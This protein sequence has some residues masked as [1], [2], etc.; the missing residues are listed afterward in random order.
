MIIVTGGAGFIGS[1][2]VWRLNEAGIKDILVVDQKA[3]G[4][5]KWSNLKKRRY[6][7]YLE[8]DALLSE[9]A[10]GKLSGKVEAVFHMGA[11]SSTTEMDTAYLRENNSLYSE[12]I[13]EF[14]LREGAYLC[15]ASSAATYGDGERG[16]DDRDELTPGLKPL[17][18]YG[19]SKLDFDRWVLDHGH[20]NRLTGLRFFNVYGP[21]EYHKDTMR[22]LVN[23][24]YEQV[25]DT[26]RL[27]LFK[28]YRPE[29]PDGGQRR[30][31]VY[32]KDVVEAM[33]WL[34]RNPGVKGIY[35]IGAGRAQSWNELAAALFTAMD[36]PLNVEYI[37]MPESI[38][39][40]YQYFTM[41]DMTKLRKAGCTTD[42][43]PVEGGVS[44]YVRN[45]LSKPDPYL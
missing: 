29:Y 35:N 15:Y 38:R 32:V 1:V 13:A 41:A 8:S 37:D 3:E 43:R 12:R 6:T 36:R 42:F 4:S 22:S 39:G 33:W 44:D 7:A 9:I 10:S 23:K 5:P 25:R 30:D 16:F 24:G 31:F 40:Q 45:Y 34:Y 20:E 17:N 11:C 28:S 26:G 21:N 14:C 2:M 19:R 27:R 18:P